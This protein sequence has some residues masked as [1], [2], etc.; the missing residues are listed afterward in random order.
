[1]LP[2]FQ[3]YDHTNYARWG[4]VYIAEMNQLPQEVQ[5]EFEQGNFVVKR[6]NQKFNQVDPDHSQEW[7][8]GIGEKRRR[9][10]RYH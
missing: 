10:Y 8:N 5:T 2:F 7:L 6:S 4:A 9:Y 3:R 1:M